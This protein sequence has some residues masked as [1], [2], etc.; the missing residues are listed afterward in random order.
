[1]GHTDRTA[2]LTAETGVHAYGMSP[3]VFRP[4]VESNATISFR[5]LETISRRLSGQ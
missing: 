1:M 2:T 4:L 3:W 5:L